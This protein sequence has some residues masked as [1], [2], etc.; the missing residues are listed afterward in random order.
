MVTER[1]FPCYKTKWNCQWWENEVFSKRENTVK[2]WLW[3]FQKY[4]QQGCQSFSPKYG[5]SSMSRLRL[6]LLVQLL[7]FKFW[8][9]SDVF[10][11]PNRNSPFVTSSFQEIFLGFFSPK[12]CLFYLLAVC[13]CVYL[14]SHLPGRPCIDP[15]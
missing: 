2:H 9:I 8:F 3:I 15:K 6:R 4:L 12:I 10:V 5:K 14:F 1:I 13:S 11:L 7:K